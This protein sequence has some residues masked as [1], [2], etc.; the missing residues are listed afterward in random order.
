MSETS[1]KPGETERLMPSFDAWRVWENP[2]VWKNYRSRMRMQALFNFLLVF[3]ISSFMTFTI[4]GGVERFQG[5]TVMAARSAIAPL[6]ILQWII[7]MLSATGRITSGI[8]HERVTDTIEYTRLT[9]LS[10]LTK[11]IGY[12]FGL[13]VREYLILLMTMPF[14]IFLLI[15]GEIPLSVVIP[16]YLVFFSSAILFHMLGMV[17]GLV[18]MEWRLSVVLTIGLVIAI[19]WVL[20]FFA[21][22]GFPFVFLLALL[23]KENGALIPVYLLAVE[24]LVFKFHYPDV[25]VKKS[26]WIFLGIFSVLPLL[27]GALYFFTHFDSFVDYSIRDFTMTERLM[28]QLHVIPFYLKLIYLPRL[29]DMSLFHDD[30]MAIQQMDLLT[31]FLLL[32]FIGSLFLIVYCWKKA[33]VLAFAIA[34]FIIS[35]LLESTFISLELIFEHRNY[36]AAV[37]PIVAMVYYLF[38]VAHYPNLKFIS[39]FLLIFWTFLTATRVGEWRS[40]DLIYRIA[41]QEHPDSLRANIEFANMNYNEGNIGAALTY[42]QLSQEVQPREAGSFFHES[43]FR[44]D[45][46][47]SVDELL[48]QAQQRLALYPVSVYTINSL[49]AILGKKR[50]EQ[51]PEV[52]LDKIL[53]IIVVAKQHPAIQDNNLY[54]GYLERLE[55]QAY[56][57]SGNYEPGVE[58]LLRAYEYTGLVSILLELVDVQI[59]VNRLEDAAGLIAEIQRINDASFGIE[60]SRLVILQEAFNQALLARQESLDN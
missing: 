34:W 43:L 31:V 11:V 26:L 48:E 18:M 42:L 16:V 10:P 35:H 7:L 15:V 2:I 23:S 55:G 5:D 45:T 8:I 37:G 21:Y 28:T 32:L 6:G 4:Y 19:N 54:Q 36:L 50:V 30:A 53:E 3:I 27:L 39:V 13:P 60:T 59:Q 29:S 51:C 52:S 56:F 9:P 57:Y 17:L 1:I 38:S 40:A 25:G 58:R 47:T 20:P 33:P 22:L 14:M 24:M 44:C 12:L 46:G 49:D 41:V